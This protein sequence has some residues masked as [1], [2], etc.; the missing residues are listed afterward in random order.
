MCKPGAANEEREH[1]GSER[2]IFSW[3]TDER[4]FH[5]PTIFVPAFAL[6]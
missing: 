2:G 1:P 5:P 4:S 6:R 3:G